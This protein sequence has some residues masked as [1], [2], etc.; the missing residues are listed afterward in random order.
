MSIKPKQKATAQTASKMTEAA[1]KTKRRAIFEAFRMAGEEAVNYAREIDTYLDQTSNLRSSIGFT[2]A[3]NGTVIESS[4]F[5]Q[6]P[7]KN[8]HPGDVYDGGDRGKSKSLQLVQ[9]APKSD[10]LLVL[11]AG[12]PYAKWVEVKHNL[13]VLSGAGIVM[14]N[15]LKDNL[16]AIK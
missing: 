8:P 11:V 10:F 15:E 16:K 2:I 9:D 12:M 7:P 6:I 1:L 13:E 5:E 14:K 4:S 3:E